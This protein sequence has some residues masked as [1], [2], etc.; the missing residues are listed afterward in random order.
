MEKFKNIKEPNVHQSIPDQEQA[1]M[2]LSPVSQE[3]M[4]AELHNMREAAKEGLTTTYPEDI[5][6][7]PEP[8]N[9]SQPATSEGD[10]ERI[11][12]IKMELKQQQP[13]L[14]EQM[15]AAV[16][17][18]KVEGSGGDDEP[19]PV[20]VQEGKADIQREVCPKCG[21]KGTKWLVF[22]CGRC[23]GY[24]SIAVSE[25][26]NW[27]EKALKPRKTAPHFDNLNTDSEAK[28]D[29]REKERSK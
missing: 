21:G 1:D 20:I 28:T 14:Q 6:L 18:N 29:V 4:D 10:L 13:Q 7:T 8:T 22:A 15:K 27:K 25:T 17:P 23:H 16:P 5:P 12:E 3:E 2:T 26:W 19:E 11:E 9:E 24:G